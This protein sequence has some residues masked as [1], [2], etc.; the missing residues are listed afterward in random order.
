MDARMVRKILNLIYHILLFL[1][2]R[3]C[4]ICLRSDA[5]ASCVLRVCLT[6]KE[7]NR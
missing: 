1:R 7:W 5:L 6:E 3:F 2:G 4:L